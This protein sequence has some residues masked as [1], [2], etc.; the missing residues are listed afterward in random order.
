M[1]ARIPAL[2]KAMHAIAAD[3]SLTPIRAPLRE[4]GTVD[5]RLERIIRDPDITIE[6]AI[7]DLSGSVK[8]INSVV[9]RL[10]HHFE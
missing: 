8:S 10:A 5:K 4:F 7:K 3:T 6:Q 2:V 9:A 1:V